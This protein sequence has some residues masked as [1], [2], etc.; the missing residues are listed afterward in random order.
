MWASSDENVFPLKAN[1]ETA[2]V[3]IRIWQAQS[4]KDIWNSHLNK[5]H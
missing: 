2:D 4:V 1:A 3:L 5:S